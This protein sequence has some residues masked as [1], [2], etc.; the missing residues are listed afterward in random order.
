MSEAID[1]L[2]GRNPVREA[3][4]QE[5]TRV[6]KVLL[7]EGVGGPV[8]EAIRR[9]ARAHGV[10]VQVVPKARLDRLAAGAVHQGVV[11]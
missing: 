1:R 8:I 9:A 3:L 4:E 10:P 2:V 6:E 5:E 7:Q 11:A